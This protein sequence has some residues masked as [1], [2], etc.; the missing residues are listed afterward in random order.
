[1][2]W[3]KLWEF[4][5]TVWR[6]ISGCK[7]SSKQTTLLDTVSLKLFG[8]ELKVTREVP[9]GVPYELTVVVPRAELRG[10]KDS[11]NLEINLNSITIAHSPRIM[12]KTE[13]EKPGFPEPVAA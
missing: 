13:S 6:K 5:K 10:N 3:K 7:T 2:F 4:L 11:G 1:M 12:S 8:L 9:V